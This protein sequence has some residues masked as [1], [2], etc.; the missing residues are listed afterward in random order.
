MEYWG[1][2]DIIYLF[3]YAGGWGRQ[4][5]SAYTW[6]F[7]NRGPPNSWLHKIGKAEADKC[8]RHDGDAHGGGVPL[9]RS[10]KYWELRLEAE[11][12]GK[13]KWMKWKLI[14]CTT[15]LLRLAASVTQ[16]LQHR[17]ARHFSGHTIANRLSA[18]GK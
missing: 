3:I 11:V 4:A 15:F 5:L 8:G 10:T 9:H 16:K 1:G 12:S 2:E 17:T 18:G 6:C 7:T 13:N 14:T